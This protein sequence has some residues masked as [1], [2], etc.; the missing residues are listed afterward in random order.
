MSNKFETMPQAERYADRIIALD[1]RKNPVKED[2][3]NDYEA[4][5]I[6]G[7]I[8]G[9]QSQ[10]A[11]P[12]APSND[13][14][15]FQIAWELS[16]TNDKPFFID[17]V[18]A[19]IRSYD[20]EEISLSKLVEELNTMSVKWHNSQSPSNDYWMKRCEAAEAY[21][22]YTE[23][24]NFIKASSDQFQ[25]E[26]YLEGKMKSKKTWQA[27]KSNPPQKEG[28]DEIWEELLDLAEQFVIDKSFNDVPDVRIGRAILDTLKQSFSIIRKK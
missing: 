18:R 4:G 23:V 9:K 21:I 17:I 5:Y 10:P 14:T 6:R 27:L 8:D 2:I 25:W 7:I 24:E 22:G 20:D 28:E 16:Q 26:N 13:K 11:S 15:D 12:S 3:A 1:W 19:L